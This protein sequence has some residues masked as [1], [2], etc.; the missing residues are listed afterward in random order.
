MVTYSDDSA[1]DEGKAEG[2]SQTFGY[3]LSIIWVIVA[4][5]SWESLDSI[6]VKIM[7]FWII[8]PNT[9]N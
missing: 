6:L 5:N 3:V 1:E 8:I 4:H 7:L 9:G 2:F